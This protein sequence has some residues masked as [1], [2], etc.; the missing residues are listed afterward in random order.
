MLL[1]FNLATVA[2]FREPAVKD[3]SFIT[4]RRSA[5]VKTGS[6]GLPKSGTECGGILGTNGDM[7]FIYSTQVEGLV[8]CYVCGY[9]MR[10]QLM[11]GR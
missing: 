5:V 1:P 7:L 11:L 10:H 4:P 8:H 6:G 3:A 2:F 9:S